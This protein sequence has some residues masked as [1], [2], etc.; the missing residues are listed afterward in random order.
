M[1]HSS[2]INGQVTLKGIC[3]TNLDSKICQNVPLSI[4]NFDTLWNFA[5]ADIQDVVILGLD[6]LEHNKVNINLQ[7]FSISI[8]TCTVNIEPVTNDNKEK[9]DILRVQ[10]KRKVV[11][12]PKSCMYTEIQFNKQPEFDIVISSYKNS[13]GL[14]LPNCV[15]KFEQNYVF[16]KNP[17]DKFI[18]VKKIQMWALESN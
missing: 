8:G 7:D 1:H 5:V 11:T 2:K 3:N 15:N 4:G 10:M 13:I 18:T 6:F 17:T 9:I 14:L 16:L 12:P